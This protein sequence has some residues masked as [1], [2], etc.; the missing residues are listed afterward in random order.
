MA[1]LVR[2]DELM[3][4]SETTAVAVGDLTFDVRLAGPEDGPPVVLL[5]G[6][7]ASSLSW[8]HVAPALADAGLRVIAPDQRGYSP[9]ARPTD[10]AAYATD[11]LA[12]D[13][14][15]LADAFGLERFHLVG[16]DWGA[17]VAWYVAAHHG[18]RLETLTTFSVPH[19]AAYNAALAHDAD[20]RERGSY[21]GLFRQ[22]G[23][24]EDLLLADDARRLRAMY[25]GAVP[26][27]LVD[28]YVA[29]LQEPG[30]LTAALGW[31]RAMT[32]ELAGLPSVDVPTTFVWSD[33]DLAIGRA[34]ADACGAHVSADYRYEVLE[35]VTHWIPEQA[36]DAAAAA[37][38]ARVRGVEA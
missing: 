7:P 11:R 23:T 32:P 14:V 34:G 9:G 2:H 21:I 36:P 37:I 20:A 6:F 16:H 38:L 31:Y 4:F 18:H 13:V 17:A 15:S 8:S 33:D 24:A 3:A 25:Q 26:A 19:L 30:A 22:E 10:V 12:Q 5:H 28:A 1:P 35:G 27:H 29:Q